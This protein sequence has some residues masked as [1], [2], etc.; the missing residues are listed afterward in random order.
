MTPSRDDLQLL[1]ICYFGR[2]GDPSGLSYWVSQGVDQAAFS[3]MVYGQAEFQQTLLNLDTRSQVNSLYLNLFG[4]QGDSE[5]LSYWSQAIESGRL[6]LA[7]LGVDLVYAARLRDEADSAVLT[8]KLS[9]ANRWTD[10]ITSNV[11]LT[12]NYQPTSW[13][14]WNS[15]SALQ[16][17][18]SL[19]TGVTGASTIP[20]DVKLDKALV[21]VQ[22]RNGVLSDLEVAY[23]RLSGEAKS[24]VDPTTVSYATVT[25]GSVGMSTSEW[26]RYSAKP[27]WSSSSLGYTHYYYLH[28]ANDRFSLSETERTIWQKVFNDL[29]SGFQ[30]FLPI[31]FQPAAAARDATLVLYNTFERSGNTLA[32]TTAPVNG[33]DV[34]SG[35]WQTI[36]TIRDSITGYLGTNTSSFSDFYRFIALHELG[37]ALG[38]DHPF[39]NTLW[40]GVRTTDNPSKTGPLPSETVMTYNFNLRTITSQYAPADLQA[41]QYIWGTPTSPNMVFSD[42]FEAVARQAT[43][44]QSY[45]LSRSAVPF[46][47]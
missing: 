17:G 45:I 39:V 29:D 31:R 35:F 13:S 19:L 33:S 18:R 12:L 32:F 23:G 43:Q 4:R 25:S 3:R 42:A 36:T 38:L 1:Y 40:P 28:N 47:V 30:Q 7:T 27:N 41:L 8:A 46:D 37:H 5:G 6:R 15:G 9:T 24:L 11:N 2:P 14:P 21:S 22:A 20:S 26:A 16:S 10:R 34:A 44:D